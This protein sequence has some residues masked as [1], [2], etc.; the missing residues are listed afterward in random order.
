MLQKHLSGPFA[1]NGGELLLGFDAVVVD[2]Q[3]LA[4]R[5][6]AHQSG[7]HG[8]LVWRGSRCYVDAGLR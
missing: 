6:S 1:V 7:K 8:G 2:A 3:K 5:G 4:L